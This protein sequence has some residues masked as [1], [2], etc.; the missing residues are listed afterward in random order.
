M[1]PPHLK[2]R[3]KKENKFRKEDSRMPR[4]VHFLEYKYTP[5]P[6]KNQLQNITKA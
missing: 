6:K 1:I 4:D 5:P 3:K 2:K